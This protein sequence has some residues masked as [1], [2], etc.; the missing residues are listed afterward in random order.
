MGQRCLAES[1]LSRNGEPTESVGIQWQSLI[2]RIPRTGKKG[3]AIEELLSSD[4]SDSIGL[5]VLLNLL[6]R[7]PQEAK[8]SAEGRE[9]VRHAARHRQIQA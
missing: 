5:M 7:D 3:R 1:I 6:Q 8:A 9:L 4:Y 2:S